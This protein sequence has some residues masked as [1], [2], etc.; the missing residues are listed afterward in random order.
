[1][2]LYLF[3][4]EEHG[5]EL[6]GADACSSG[7]Q[8]FSARAPL[9]SVNGSYTAEEA[10]KERTSAWKRKG[11]ILSDKDVVNAMD[12]TD[13]LSR[14]SCKENKNGDLVGDI[15]DREQ[16]KLLKK[17]IFDYVGHLVDEIASGNVDANPYTRGA[18][19]GACTYCP[20]SSVCSTENIPGRRV[21]KSINSKEFWEQ[22]ERSVNDRG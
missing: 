1:M 15:A 6:L 3:A 21:Y 5:A 11:L 7:V 13:G 8:Y 12:H 22:I 10:A 4:L 2:L 14:L 9:I 20:Y 18:G 16:F 17:Y 19:S